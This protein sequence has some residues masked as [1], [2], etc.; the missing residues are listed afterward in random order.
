MSETDVRDERLAQ[1]LDRAVR[2]VRPSPAPERAIRRGGA[3]RAAWLATS[4]ATVS[5]FVAGAIWAATVVGSDE[6]Q[7]VDRSAPASFSAPEAPWTFEYPSAWSVATTSRAAPDLITNVLRTAVANAPIPHDAAYGPNSSANASSLFSDGGAVVLIERLWT[8]AMP[9]GGEDR[10]PGPFSDDAQNPGW[11]FR[12]RARCE[13]T[14]CFHVVEWFGPAATPEERAAAAEVA[15]SVRL[16]D[17]DRWTE[18]DGVFTTLHDEDDLFTVTYPADWAASDVPINDRVC[19]PFEILALAT[20]PP[21]PG[22]EAVMDAQLPSHA[23]EDLGLNDILIWL[24]DAGS[25]CGGGR[26]SDGGGP[27]RPE[28]FE[29]SEPC[30]GWTQLCPEPTGRRLGGTQALQ[31]IRGWWL[32][33]DDAGRGFYVFVGMGEEAFAD[34]ARA[35]L[36]WDVLDSLRFLPR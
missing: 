5:V 20:Y 15:D 27:E 1:V 33:F 23:V 2:D 25:A 7:P 14:L 28:H 11:T 26:R 16:A 17:V 10:G 30:E 3:R 19:S 4:V 13:G 9:L 24:N 35:Q 6:R 18:T 8:H 34:P 21:R 22:G 12:E 36:A 29:P 32:G 31:L